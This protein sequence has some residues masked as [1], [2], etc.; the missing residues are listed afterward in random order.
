MRRGSLAFAAL[1]ASAGIHVGAAALGMALMGPRTVPHQPTPSA[2]LVMATLSVPSG[3]AKEAAP[4]ARQLPQG[5]PSAQGA[6]T[7]AI[8]K[9]RAKPLH[10]T[11]DPAP[12][13][14][15]ATASVQPAPFAAAAP[16]FP[17][18]AQ[19]E[20]TAP[21]PIAAQTV[22]ASAP[23]SSAKTNSAA[24]RLPARPVQAYGHHCTE[25]SH[26]SDSHTSPLTTSETKDAKD[27]LAQRCRGN[28]Q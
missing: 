19:R 16:L 5:R 28:W 6:V 25:E 14:N 10:M 26:I 22:S 2:K 20:E 1:L 12:A 23:A 27:T 8:P 11:G 24:R 7:P 21:A 13:V 3:D 17:T 9:T 15:T 18:N 4:D